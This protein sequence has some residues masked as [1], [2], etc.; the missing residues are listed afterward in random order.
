M[1]I[2]N[3]FGPNVGW[4][5][6]K[7]YARKMTRSRRRYSRPRRPARFTRGGYYGRYDSHGGR[8]WSGEYKFHD[9]A[10][11]DAVIASTGQ[12]TPS[13]NLISQ[14]VTESERI[15]RK[16]TIKKIDWRIA[17][18]KNSGGDLNG[19]DVVRLILYVDKQCNGATIAVTDILENADW[20]SI[21]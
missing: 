14:G 13:C 1:S 9:L 6:R 21:G 20:Q 2:W 18:R 17:M 11:T 4:Y 7:A 8:N 15:G 12:V 5:G 10:V 16:C 19:S 3:P